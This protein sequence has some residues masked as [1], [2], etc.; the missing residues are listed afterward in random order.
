MSENKA[1]SYSEKYRL[2]KSKEFQFERPYLRN[3]YRT[4][5]CLKKKNNL[6]TKRSRLG[7]KVSS[8]FFN[9]VLRNQIKRFCREEFRKSIVK[10]FGLDMIIVVNR[11]LNEFNNEKKKL[12]KKDI[13]SD[14][15]WIK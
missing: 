7:I 15:S 12:L 1:H 14:I 9:S 13:E 4:L 11:N 5:L 8:R 6:T 2:K 3:E 10:D